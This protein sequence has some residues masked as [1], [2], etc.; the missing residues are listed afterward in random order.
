MLKGVLGKE[1]KKKNY[2]Q[3]KNRSIKPSR[4]RVKDIQTKEKN[5]NRSKSLS[6]TTLNANGLGSQR[7][8]N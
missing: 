7:P 1:A 8:K 2:Y 3:H 5:S 6:I 4:K